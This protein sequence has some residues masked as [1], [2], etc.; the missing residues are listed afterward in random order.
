MISIEM[1]TKDDK[2]IM[3][4]VNAILNQNFS[5]YEIILVDSS[6]KNNESEF[7]NFKSIKYIYDKDSNFLKARFTANKMARGDYVLLLDSTRIIN[8]KIIQKCLNELSTKDMVIIPEINKSK[9]KILNEYEKNIDEEYVLSNSNPSNGIFIPRFYKKE[10]LDK[11]FEEIMQKI[12][13]EMENICALEDRMIFLEACKISNKIGV[14]DDYIIHRESS[15][16]IDY[17]KKYYKYGK[18]NYYFFSKISSYSYL[19]D[20]KIKR[21][22][23]LNALNNKSFKIKIL[24]LIRSFSFIVGFFSSKF[25]GS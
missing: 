4:S 25:F 22:N 2:Y 10:I 18:C 20:P 12:G 21:K 19:A 11:A 16:L 17:M 15:S 6:S 13:N 9:S 5:D 3:E 24:F 1:I 7:S 14:C 23:K 8:D